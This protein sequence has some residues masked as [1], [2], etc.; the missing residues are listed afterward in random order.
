MKKRILVLL[1]GA[2]MALTPMT[3]SAA[4][5]FVGG[6]FYYGP[7]WYA[8]YWGPYWGPGY[9]YGYRWPVK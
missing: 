7:G 5:V 1:A 4:R 3:A 2:V 9:Y 6:G 8:P